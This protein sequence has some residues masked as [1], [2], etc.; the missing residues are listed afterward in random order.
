MSLS[1]RRKQKA[2]QAK[3]A[4]KATKNSYPEGALRSIAI[5][6]KYMEHEAPVDEDGRPV[7]KSV[8]DAKGHF[9]AEI[10]EAEVSKDRVVNN[11]TFFK[12]INKTVAEPIFGVPLRA[13]I[14]RMF[15]EGTSDQ[16]LTLAEQGWRVK[17]PNLATFGRV[18]RQA[19]KARNPRTG[20][21]VHVP[22]RT[23]L[24]AKPTRSAREFMKQAG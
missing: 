18:E 2:G 9:A 12:H 10:T 21:T 19:R 6:R 20:E 3:K 16:I 7:F 17:M 8:F 1:A 24:T 4:P 22:A 11:S 14:I 13:K 15:L 23:A 5:G